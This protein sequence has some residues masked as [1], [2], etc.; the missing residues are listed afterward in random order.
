MLC[1]WS[2]ETVVMKCILCEKNKDLVDF[3]FVDYVK[4]FD[5]LTSVW[6]YNA[7]LFFPSQYV[8]R[9]LRQSISVMMNLNLLTAES[10]HFRPAISV[11]NSTFTLFRR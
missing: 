7:S 8:T 6:P 5:N 4:L 9:D 2:L 11:L 10:G 1:R 3:C